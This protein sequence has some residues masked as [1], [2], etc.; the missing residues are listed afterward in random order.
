MAHAFHSSTCEAE[1]GGS[2]FH[3]SLVSVGSSVSRGKHS[4]LAFG[5]HMVEFIHVHMHAYIQIFFRA[6]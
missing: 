5:I 4:A 1:A 6:L 2:E 3:T